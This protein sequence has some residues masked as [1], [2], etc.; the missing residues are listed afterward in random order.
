MATP[1]L[2][3]HHRDTL[4]RI[5]DRPSSAN[6]DWREVRSLL[7]AAGTVVEEP[8]GKLRVTLGAETEVI[9]PPRGKDVDQQLLVDLRR[10]L[11]NAGYGPE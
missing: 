10:M 7:E 5:F 4:E 3:S 2:G 11:G 8:N 6:V 1:P 9:D